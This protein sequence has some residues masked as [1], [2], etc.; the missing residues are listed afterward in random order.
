VVTVL[1]N[2]TVLGTATANLSGVWNFNTATLAL[3]GHSFT[4]SATDAAGNTGTSTALGVTVEAPPANLAPTDIKFSLN[5][6]SANNQGSN[7]GSGDPLGT[8]AAVDPDS[9]G[10]TFALGGPNSG[11]FA[12]DPTTG[13]LSVGGSNLGANTYVITITATDDSGNASTPETFTIWV[14]TTSGSDGSATTPIL[15]SAGSD[16]DFALNGADFISGGDGDDALVGGQAGDTLI[17]ARG[18]DELLGG[19][20][21]DLYVFR[22]ESG[23]TVLSHYGVDRILDMNASG[24]DT[25]R[26]DD[27]LFGGIGTPGSPLAGAFK[28]DG[29]AIDANDRI[30]YNQTTGAL[31]YDA[32][33]SGNASTAVQ[34]AQLDPGTALTLSDFNHSS[35]S[36][37]IAKMVPSQ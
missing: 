31:Y 11:N 28:L 2:A 16:I 12:I 26:L 4:A 14:G 27:G 37:L 1:D 17:G 7:L 15:I 29:S 33:G 24:D 34:F 13:I 9:S 23:D 32:D 22:V 18:S 10:W 5:E 21:N 6:V 35:P 3:G 30:I 25:I 8:F 36:S 19:A 20:G